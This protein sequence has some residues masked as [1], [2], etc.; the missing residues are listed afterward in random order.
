MRNLSTKLFSDLV[1][2]KLDELGYEQT[3]TNP[4]T[5][6]KTNE[7]IE[8]HTPLKSNN[9]TKR[10]LPLRS[11]FQMSITCW[12]REQRKAMEMTDE[13][14]AKLQEYNFVRTNTSPAIYDTI[15]QKYGITI[16]FEVRYNAIMDS[17]EQ[18]R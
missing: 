16:T 11:T 13:V 17:F 12:N 18:I 2:E 5:E 6:D 15:L 8:L 9:K 1:Y 7:I 10:A 4:T 14:E 3:L